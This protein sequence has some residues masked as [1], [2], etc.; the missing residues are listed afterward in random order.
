MSL[1]ENKQSDN[2]QLESSATAKKWIAVAAFELV[3][4]VILLVLFA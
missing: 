4:I 2:D 1:N 3:V